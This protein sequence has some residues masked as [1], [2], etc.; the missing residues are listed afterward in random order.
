MLVVVMSGLV[1]LHLVKLVLVR[2]YIENDQSTN[3]SEAFPTTLFQ[4]KKNIKP[5]FK[6]EFIK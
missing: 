6:S 1:I 5:N 3:R 4:S 2:C